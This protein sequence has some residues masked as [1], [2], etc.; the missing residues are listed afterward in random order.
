MFSTHVTRLLYGS[1]KSLSKTSSLIQQ[2]LAVLVTSG[3]PYLY[4]TL[5]TVVRDTF[6]ANLTFMTENH[7]MLICDSKKD[8]VNRSSYVNIFYIFCP[9]IS[10]SFLN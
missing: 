2:N 9:F 10:S 1:Q 8:Y 6:A 5:S 7:A 4:K 3:G